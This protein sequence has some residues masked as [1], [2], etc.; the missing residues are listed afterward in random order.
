VSRS[1]CFDTLATD[2][3]EMA[4]RAQ[5]A[6]RIDLLRARLALADGARVLEPGCG[7]GHLTERLV[8]WVGVTG[9]VVAFDPCERL[10]REARRRLDGEARVSL[11]LG[12]MEGVDLP[13]RAFDCAVCFRVW[14]HLSDTEASLVQLA[15][16]LTPLGRLVIAHWHGRERLAA[17]HA[18]YQALAADLFPPRSQLESMLERHGFRVC[19][20]IDDE[21]EIHIE[22]RLG[23]GGPSAAG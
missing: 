14:P 23:R 10:L 22:A 6:G 17:I 21:E 2:G 16:W 19:R 18:R 20:W 15:R 7:A 5:D 3:D 12:A 9:S 11:L 4:F 8:S 1:A 13:A